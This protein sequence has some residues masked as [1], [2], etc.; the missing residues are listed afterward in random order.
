MVMT[1]RQGRGR[2]RFRRRWPGMVVGEMRL[3]AQVRDASG[4]RGAICS[5]RGRHRARQRHAAGDGPRSTSP[6]ACR[7]GGALPRRRGIA[8]ARRT[9]AAMP[10]RRHTCAMP[11]AATTDLPFPPGSPQLIE[12]RMASAIVPMPHDRPRCLFQLTSATG[13]RAAEKAADQFSY[14]AI[15][16]YYMT[17]IQAS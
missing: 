11:P 2:A 14:R 10:S 8:G 1:G 15:D 6:S 9:S 5:L 4:C 13:R 3:D 12:R 7:E 17:R 16:H